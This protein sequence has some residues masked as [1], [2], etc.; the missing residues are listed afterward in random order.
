MESFDAHTPTTAEDP[1]LGLSI[2]AKMEIL[3]AVLLGMFLSALDQ[4]IVGPVLPKIVS[5]LHG[6]DVYTW[7]VT[8][9]LLTSTVT[10]PIYGKL[11]D[12][13]GRKPILMIG[14]TLFL[15]GSALSGLSQEMWQLVLFRGIQGLGA[16]ALFPIALA[17]IGDLF[18]PAERGK[19][20]GLFGLVFG[21][22]FLA[23]PAIGG[24]LTDNFSWHAIFYVN[25]PIGAIALL[26]IWRLLP[27]IKHVERVGKI[28]YAGVVTLTLGLVP[29]LIGF[30]V[31]ET[32][33]FGDPYFW[34][35]IAASAIFLTIFVFVE[36][37]S[38]EPVIPLRLFRNRTF[39]SSML[40]IF[41]ATFGFGA[42]IIFLPLY[43]L[44]VQGVTYTQSGYQLLPFMFGLILASISSGQIVARTGRYKPVILVGLV[45]LILGMGLMTQ[46]RADTAPLTLSLW[47]FVAGLGV[48]PTF[49]VFTIIVQNAVD[50][51]DLG[52]AT[53]DLTL[54]RQIGTTIG[55]AAAFSLFRLNF[56]WDLLRQQLISAGAPEAFVPATPPPG[57][58]LGAVTNVSSGGGAADFLANIPAQFQPI[59]V[60]GFH[61]ALTIAIGN[62]IWLGVAAS[63]IALV[64][65]FALRE[66]PLRSTHA[67]GR[68]GA[69]APARAGAPQAAAGID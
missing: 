55:I 1:A 21:V 16:G 24:T 42:V 27:N 2:R 9:Y 41:F 46:L 10:V 63:A 3:G 52:A 30:T 59:F 64:A 43:F 4:T 54:F 60:D 53:S 56:T 68:S 48:G 45:L 44:I 19:Y 40:A 38:P 36:R 66:I 51:K 29:L 61:R 65:A 37:R 6:S 17:I 14:I 26:V 12:L 5:D 39:S 34:A 33:G 7:A 47:M 35:W 67:P 18:T 31:A 28:D 49:A 13:Y 11:S 20:Q 57:V 62:S 15:A 50:F 23:G 32:S 22:A 69:G 25:L 58:D 8:I